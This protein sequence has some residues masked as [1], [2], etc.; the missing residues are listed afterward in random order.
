MLLNTR[1]LVSFSTF[2]FFLLQFIQRI[3]N[4]IIQSDVSSLHLE[5]ADKK[6]SKTRSLLLSSQKSNRGYGPSIIILESR[7]TCQLNCVVS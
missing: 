1:L 2:D 3:H 5:I 7:F 4:Y 6:P